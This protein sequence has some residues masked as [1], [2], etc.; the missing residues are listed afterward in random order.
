MSGRSRR[1]AQQRLRVPPSDSLARRLL[2]FLPV[3]LPAVVIV[4]AG[5]WFGG[6]F[7]GG[8]DSGPLPAAS[9]PVAPGGSLPAFVTAGGDRVV[10]AYEYALA[11]ADKLVYIPCYCGCGEHSGH[12]SVRDCFI[13]NLS[14]SAVEYDEHGAGCDMCVSIVLDVQR[15]LAEGKSLAE[16]RAFIDQTYADIGAPTDTPLPPEGW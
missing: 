13:R 14:A 11:A 2:G 15:L 6:F 9:R 7:S 12:K 10:A 16:A 3:A 5:L 8:G 4:A 1:H